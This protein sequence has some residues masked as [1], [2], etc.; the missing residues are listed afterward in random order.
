[1]NEFDQFVK[2]VLKVKHYLRY[3]DDFVIVSFN[4]EYLENIVPAISEFLGDQLALQLHPKKTIIR[5]Y[6]QGVDFLGYVILPYHTVLTNI[7]I[8]P[9]PNA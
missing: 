9:S 6:L 2:H 3:T 1:M 7:H 5:P 4:K 8:T